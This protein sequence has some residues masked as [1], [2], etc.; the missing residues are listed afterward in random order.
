MQSFGWESAD[1]WE[2]TEHT[3][4]ALSPSLFKHL[5]TALLANSVDF[6]PKRIW[7]LSSIDGKQSITEIGCHCYDANCLRCHLLPNRKREK[8]RHFFPPISPSVFVA[9]NKRRRD[10]KESEKTRVMKF[11]KP[12]QPSL[13]IDFFSTHF[14]SSGS[15]SNCIS[16]CLPWQLLLWQMK[17]L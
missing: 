15:F 14:S 10:R 8:K 9:I 11:V 5:V 4:P 2:S 1:W 3:T 17:R 6:P 16:R 12:V 13:N 7:G